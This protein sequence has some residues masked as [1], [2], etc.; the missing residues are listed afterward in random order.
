MQVAPYL[1]FR[2]NC[3][4]ALA[5]YAG[6][7]LGAV[8]ELRRY[9]GTPMVDRFGAAWA[10][11]VLHSCFEGPG[12]RFFASDGPDSEPMKGCALYLEVAELDEARNVF[13]GLAEGGRVTVAF[14]RQFWG[15][16]YGNLTDAFGVQW[17]MSCRAG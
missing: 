11:K 9:E 1:Y 17:A 10:D 4:P 2:G 3:G 13:A 8:K 14:T 5:R 7:G 6:L 15:E 12:V 16:W